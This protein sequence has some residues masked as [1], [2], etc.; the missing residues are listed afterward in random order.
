MKHQFPPRAR[1]SSPWQHSALRNAP[2][3]A[4]VA[5]S[6]YQKGLDLASLLP[7]PPVYHG[8]HHP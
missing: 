1:G 6:Q 4:L 2:G 8:S 7:L 3:P 5:D